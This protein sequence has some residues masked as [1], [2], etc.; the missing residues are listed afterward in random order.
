MKIL[1]ASSEI[2]PFSKSGGLADMVSSLAGSLGRLGHEVQ[3]M[4]PYYRCVEENFPDIPESSWTSQVSMGGGEVFGALRRYQWRENVEIL[5]VEHR[6]FFDRPG[7]YGEGGF[8]YNDNAARFTFLVKSIH[9]WVRF[10]DFR[11]E[12]VHIHDWQTA[13]FPLLLKHDKQIRYSDSDGIEVPD[14]AVVMTIHNLAYQGVFPSHQ[15]PLLE[16]PWDYY[17]D[18]GIEFF[19]QWNCLKAG[20]LYSDYLTTVSPQYAREIQ[21]PEHGCH[22]DGVLAKRKDALKGILNGVDYTEWKTTGNKLLPVAYQAKSIGFKSRMKQKLQKEVGLGVSTEVPLFANIGRIVEQKGM[23]ILIPALRELLESGAP[24]QYVQLGTGDPKY[25][26]QLQILASDFP[27][28]CSVQIRYDHGLAH[29]IEAGADYFVM[30]SRFE[31]CGLNQ[32]YSLRYGTIP[33]VRAT[34]GLQ[35][36][37]ADFSENV[38]LANGFKFHR[39]NKESLLHVLMQAV[40]LYE[41]KHLLNKFRKNG[42]ACDFSTDVMSEKYIEVYR[43]AI[44]KVAQQGE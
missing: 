21:L 9:H 32:L 31:P 1:L 28:K 2:F 20:I 12:I 15:Y 27:E 41:D 11:A 8:D 5:F 30:P 35:D 22:L 36:S 19:S 10:G 3:V 24:I 14:P 40:Y 29:R 25:E 39:Y 43:E 33:I 16:L 4:T 18:E 44:E 7:L 17:N 26:K 42:M 38:S 23:D 13:T 6:G 37:I 34:G